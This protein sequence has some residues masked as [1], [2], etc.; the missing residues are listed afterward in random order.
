MGILQRAVAVLIDDDS[1]G[2]VEGRPAGLCFTQNESRHR[3]MGGGGTTTVDSV[4]SLSLPT[5]RG[6]IPV[7]SKSERE[8]ESPKSRKNVEFSRRGKGL[9]DS[10]AI[11]L[12]GLIDVI[13]CKTPQVE[14]G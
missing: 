4:M 13:Q 14:V 8:A 2:S 12:V 6:S 10:F 7:H 3:R 9:K 5:R 1:A 11:F